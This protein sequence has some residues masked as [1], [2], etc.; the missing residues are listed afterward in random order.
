VWPLLVGV[1]V[2]NVVPF[3]AGDVYRILAFRRQLIAPVVQLI[4]TLVIDRILDLTVLL[5]FFI[6]GVVGLNHSKN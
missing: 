6:V 2:N 1:A 3:R 4:G 5:G